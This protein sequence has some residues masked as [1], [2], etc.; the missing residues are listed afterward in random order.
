M[1]HGQVF[2][3]SDLCAFVIIYINH[4]ALSFLGELKWYCIFSQQWYCIFF[5]PKMVLHFLL[6]IHLGEQINLES[7]A[8]LHSFQLLHI[9]SSCLD[10]PQL[11]QLSPH[12]WT[13]MFLL[14]LLQTMLQGNIFVHSVE[15]FSRVNTKRELMVLRIAVATYQFAL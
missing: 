7:T 14:F 8:L 9:V 12:Q 10:V 15:Y 2:S 4:M 5:L 1:C 13:L 11:V 3:Q 6:A